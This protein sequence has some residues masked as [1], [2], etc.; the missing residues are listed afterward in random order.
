[1]R[2]VHPAR[3]VFGM[4]WFKLIQNDLDAFVNEPIC[5]RKNA[6]GVFG[7]VVAVTDENGGS[8]HGVPRW[9]G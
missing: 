3:L 9:G 6:I 4:G 1:M 7:G 8:G 2:F 5:K